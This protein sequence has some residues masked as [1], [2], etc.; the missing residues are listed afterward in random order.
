[1]KILIFF[2]W[3][4]TSMPVT[5]Q[6][7]KKAYLNKVMELCPSA[8][9][10]E[11]E[12][13]DD[14]VEIEYWCNGVLTEVGINHHKE[15]IFTETEAEIPS[16]V[17]RKIQQKLDKKYYG[18]VID[19][20]AFVNLPDTSF[21]KVELL[22][23][24]LEENIYFT[25]D[26]KY[27]KPTNISVN[28]SWDMKSLS[29]AS[30][31]ENAPYD[32]LSPQRTYDM[33]EA[34]KEISGI[35]W[36]GNNTLYCVQ[37]ETGIIFKYN[38]EKEELTGMIRFTDIG[39]FEDIALYGDTAYVLRSDGTLFYFNHINFTGKYKQTIVPLGCMNIEG[40]YLDI[41]TRSFLITCKD[42]LINTFGSLRSVYTFSSMNK[43]M[44][45]TAFSIDLDEINKMLTVKY[46][47]LTQV[48]VQF[49]P[50]AIA[51]HPITRE[52]YIL[53]AD[54]RMLAIY[55]N[56]KLM[57]L[58]PLPAELYFKPEGIDFTENGDLFIS[59]EGMK[60][61]YLDGQI[62]FFKMRQ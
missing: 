5:G 15:V 16:E 40:L 12:T 19:E 48:K 21:F 8:D 14:Y 55:K 9:I 35:V 25:I 52:T 31:Y 30:H 3:L 27:Y 4:L 45:E 41:S 62:F 54:N 61:G 42:Q 6:P 51:I 24:G 56:K 13:K 22:K 39:D 53:S 59:N 23:G 47:G 46:S 38:I 49:N 58:F 11:V 60:K 10:V 28:E 34:L 43:H 33:P 37:D 29:N 17:M 1:M 50:S 18:W 7:E 26:G 44:P 32:F 36:A 2:V 20:Y 57:D